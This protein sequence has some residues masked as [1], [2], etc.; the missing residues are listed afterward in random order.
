MRFAFTDAAPTPRD[1][2]QFRYRWANLHRPKSKR[3]RSSRQTKKT[4]ADTMRAVFHTFTHSIN[5]FECLQ[6]R[7]TLPRTILQTPPAPTRLLAAASASVIPKGK[8]RRSRID[9][10]RAFPERHQRN[11]SILGKDPSC[12]APARTCFYYKKRQT[13]ENIKNNTRLKK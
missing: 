11:S 2:K 9:S 6:A 7:F 4:N 5:T 3:H 13:T 8:L 10:M 1:W 12:P